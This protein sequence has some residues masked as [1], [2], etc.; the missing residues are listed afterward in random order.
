MNALIDAALG[1]SRMVLATLVLIVL[2][3]ALSYG[4]IPKEADPDVN[5]PIIYVRL[6]LEGISPE[7][8]ERLLVRPIEHKLK[9]IEGVKEIRST[10]REG[11]A[12]VI[13][14]FDAG[15]N[16]D[17]AMIDVREKVDEAKPDLPDEAE[18]PT[19]HEVNVGLFPVLVVALSG[20]VPERTLLSVARNLKDEIQ[21]IPAVLSA[22]LSGHRDELLEV[23]VDP[24]RLEALQV[25]QSE[26]IQAVTLNN[27]LVAAGALDTG[28]GRFAI[29][30]PG[31]F[32]NPT[33]VMKMP[34]KVK[35]DGVVKLGDV[36]SVRRSF[37]D[38]TQFARVNG[39]PTIAVE[40]KKRLGTNIIDTIEEVR[41]VVAEVRP[42]WPAGIQVDFLQDRSTDIRTMLADL[43]NNA[44][45]AI[46]L[47]MVVTVA[48]LGLR[49]STLIG[50]AVPSSFLFGMLVLDSLDFTVNIVVLFALILAVG[51]LV[52][53]ATIVVEYA[54]RKMV[55]G[56]PRKDA[57]AQAAKRMAWPVVASVATTLAAFMPLLFWPGVVG[58]FMKFL[59]LTLIATMVGSL[60]VA[61]IFLPPLGALFARP[62]AQDPAEARNLASM[63]TGRI[64]D[65]R[66]WTGA[67]ARMLHA[68]ARHPTKVVLLAAATLVAVQTAYWSL[69]RGVEFFPDVEP[70][71]ALVYV[72]ARGNLA[73][74]EKNELVRQ[75]EAEVLQV[76][77]I[78]TVYSRIGGNNAAGSDEKSEDVIGTLFLEFTDWEGRPKASHMLSE[79]RARTA[80]L[81][82]LVVEAKKPRAG[83][84]AVK[85]IQIELRSRQPERLDGAAGR[86][87]EHLLTV[88]GLQ[89]VE[90]SRPM[91]GIQWALQVDRAQAGRFGADVS[92]VG[93]V[94]QLVTNGIKLGEY[95]PDDSDEEIDIRVRYPAEQRGVDQL[96]RLRVQTRDGLVPIANF[97]ERKAEPRTGTLNRT[98]G[99]RALR[100]LANVEEGL[101]VDDKVREL[102]AWLERHPLDPAVTVKFKGSDKD[103][104]EAQA[105]L[106]K[107]FGMAIFLMAIILV[108]Q[109]NSFY[110]VF[111]I[112]TA[113]IMST[114]GVFLGLIITGQTFGIVMTGIGIIS[115]AGI[116]VGNNI[117][118]IDTYAILRKAGMAP[119]EAVWRTGAQR[120]RPVMLTTVTT[121]VG[122]IPMML[123]V[124]IDFVAA[125][126][127]I[128]APATQWWVQ[129]STAVAF[130]LTFATCLTLIVTPCL[131]ML[132]ENVGAWRARRRQRPAQAGL[133]QALPQAAE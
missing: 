93:Y 104:Q 71:R 126:I 51:M 108:T 48:A 87:R 16:A 102:K 118:L 101:L 35:G 92:T 66:G 67:Y 19:V 17:Q 57:Y 37:K 112:L 32:E 132:G 133:N 59:P 103:Q 3:G 65:I 78:R 105:F 74:E 55:E 28:Q 70:D 111:L 45:S 1:R 84:P 43:E 99:Y 47:V 117:V 58:E 82:G 10:A 25:T 21:G 75:V 31:L 88:P 36:A 96:D 62:S 50:I 83:P 89:D 7:D 13:L 11:G 106:Q 73:S 122:L 114:V 113:I 100:V 52:D 76:A 8:A 49:S 20:S 120:L 2:M 97:V 130:G 94:V 41:R 12:S 42:A 125:D 110:R 80:G 68:V 5:I 24:A 109:F 121:I 27:R 64:E 26:L 119:L 40:V 95:R 86:L 127:S 18:E 38:P 79:I 54:D 115:L 63:E 44:I 77:G 23:L 128:G 9:A 6:A 90:D 22:E 33:D 131:L 29:K 30:V 91:P 60:L 72:H 123:Q 34:V 53:G 69:G 4:T 61:L 81:P 46:L 116:V 129:L 14:K 39:R 107:A 124:N 56:L 98:D 85:D 15:F